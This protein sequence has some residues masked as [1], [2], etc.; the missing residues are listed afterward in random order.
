MSSVHKGSLLFFQ[1]ECLPFLFS[2][3][4]EIARTSGTTKR[5][6]GQLYSVPEPR[7]WGASLFTTKYD[8]SGG[9]CGC[10]LTEEAPFSSPPILSLLRLFIRSG[11]WILSNAFSLSTDTENTMITDRRAQIQEWPL[12]FLRKKERRKKKPDSVEGA[13]LGE[14]GLPRLCSA[15]LL[16]SGIPGVQILARGLQSQGSLHQTLKRLLT[17]ELCLDKAPKMDKTLILSKIEN[18]SSYLLSTCGI[19]RT[20]AGTRVRWGAICGCRRYPQGCGCLSQRTLILALQ[21]TVLNTP[22]ILQQP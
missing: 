15:L 4:N 7:G 18:K 1:A 21:G 11:C 6:S 17:L 13:C 8:V 9:V 16:L 14:L 5:S 10:R 22:L 19:P 3:L 12:P 2:C 20:S